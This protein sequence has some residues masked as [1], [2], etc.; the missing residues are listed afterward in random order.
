MT[1]LGKNQTFDLPTWNGESGHRYKIFRSKLIWIKASTQDDKLNL[2]APKVIERFTGHVSK[3]FEDADPAYY[4]VPEGIDRL[5]EFLDR[6]FGEATDIE[7][8]TSAR[9]FF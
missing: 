9:S 6:K 5:V 2:L 8:T 3:L 7:L 1:S 4:R